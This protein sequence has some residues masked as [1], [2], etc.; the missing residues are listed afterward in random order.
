MRAS[1][2]PGAADGAKRRPSDT[3]RRRSAFVARWTSAKR[4]GGAWAKARARFPPADP[5]RAKPMGAASGRRTKPVPDARD[6]RK[7]KSPETAAC[8]AGPPPWRRE[9]RQVKRYVGPS[10]RKRG[11]YLSRG[12][13]S[14]GRIPRAPPVRNKTGTGSEGVS[15]QE[16]NQTLQ[17]ERSGCWHRPRQVDFRVFERCRERKPRRGACRLRLAG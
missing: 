6:S 16:G 7:G 12:E 3:P 15:R 1:G 5:R 14:E 2:L 11:G 9:H 10:A 17:A 4:A 8:W 13:S